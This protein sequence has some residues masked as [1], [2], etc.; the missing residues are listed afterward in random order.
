MQVLIVIRTFGN[1]RSGSVLWMTGLEQGQDFETQTDIVMA[2]WR[3]QLWESSSPLFPT[4]PCWWWRWWQCDCRVPWWESPRPPF[5][6]TSRLPQRLLPTVFH[7]VA[8]SSLVWWLPEQVPMAPAIY[9]SHPLQCCFVDNWSPFR[10]KSRQ[11]EICF[12][13]CSN[14]KAAQVSPFMG[15]GRE[16]SHDSI[17]DER[18]WKTDWMQATAHNHL[19]I[20][21]GLTLYGFRI[22][23]LDFEA[24]L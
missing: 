24:L 6:P 7:S 13:R 22:Q 14:S 12:L 2:G 15:L 4:W 1:F 3:V 23:T 10:S 5:P 21:Q 17:Q 11:P 8:A 9:I 18:W 19:C 16:R 20:F